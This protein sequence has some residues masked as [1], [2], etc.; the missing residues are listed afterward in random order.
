MSGLDGTSGREGPAGAAAALVLDGVDLA[1]GSPVDGVSEVG[2]V[3]LGV[4]GAIVGSLLEAEDSG[5]LLV[6]PGGELV[7]AELEAGLAVVNL[8][9]GSI[10]GHEDLAAVLVLGLGAELEAVVSDVL[11]KCRAVLSG[12]LALVHLESEKAGGLANSRKHN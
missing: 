1:L 8:C 12:R 6:A 11:I 7:V 2:G 9:H 10:F 5:I 4:R 3:Q